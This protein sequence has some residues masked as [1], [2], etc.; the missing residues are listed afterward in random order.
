[1]SRRVLIALAAVL[2]VL[3]AGVVVVAAV[4]SGPSD[5]DRLVTCLERHGARPDGSAAPVGSKVTFTARIGADASA[6][7]L[8][9]RGRDRRPVLIES[10]DAL[11]LD[12]R[13]GYD[14][15]RR[16]FWACVA[17][18]SPRPLP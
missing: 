8:L 16:G 14:R 5:R 15:A 3:L 12:W 18:V 9:D 7:H 10:S 11:L 2:A 13:A 6:V 1:V 17:L 4:G